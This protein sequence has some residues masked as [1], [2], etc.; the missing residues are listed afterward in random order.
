M[1][2]VESINLISGCFKSLWHPCPVN[3]QQKQKRREESKWLTGWQGCHHSGHAN[4]R[5]DCS[6]EHQGILWC[7]DRILQKSW[8]ERAC[9]QE[10]GN[11]VRSHTNQVPGSLFIF[12]IHGNQVAH[13]FGLFLP[14]CMYR[15]DWHW[16]IQPSYQDQLILDAMKLQ[17]NNW[18]KVQKSLIVYFNMTVT[19]SFYGYVACIFRRLNNF[20]PLV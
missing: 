7:Q 19:P 14:S 10:R 6:G 15:K 18:P 20:S 16:G 2:N 12:T 13:N 17:A 9:K 4:T 11:V 8:S 5:V 3:G 1:R